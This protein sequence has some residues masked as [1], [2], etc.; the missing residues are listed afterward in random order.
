VRPGAALAAQM[1]NVLETLCHARRHTPMDA[2][3]RRT[4]RAGWQALCGL[5][6][7]AGLRDVLGSADGWWETDGK[8]SMV[9]GG[10]NASNS[11][12]IG[13]ASPTPT[14]PFPGA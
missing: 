6:W 3:A 8:M 11:K 12:D 13:L 14:T 7:R 10:R 1:W 2:I 5:G 9:C 4:A